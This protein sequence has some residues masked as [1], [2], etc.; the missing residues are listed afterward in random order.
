MH[1][2]LHKR[3]MIILSLFI[4]IYMK[5][6]LFIK[7]ATMT[8]F[9]NEWRENTCLPESWTKHWSCYS[10][11]LDILEETASVDFRVAFACDLV[12]VKCIFS[13]YLDPVLYLYRV[14][15]ARVKWLKQSQKHH[16]LFFKCSVILLNGLKM[17]IIK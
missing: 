16:H 6:P 4:R 14:T 13:Y 7:Y 15:K 1:N 8:I 17:L 5:Y 11:N 9:L 12:S 10:V 2:G 3:Y